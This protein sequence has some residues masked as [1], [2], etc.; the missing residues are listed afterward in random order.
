M[1]LI[2]TFGATV[3]HCDTCHDAQIQI[4]RAEVEP[5][6]WGEVADQQLRVRARALGWHNYLHGAAHSCPECAGG[7][8]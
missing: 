1:S 3:M 7:D 2:Y 8:S 5:H 4:T 6:E